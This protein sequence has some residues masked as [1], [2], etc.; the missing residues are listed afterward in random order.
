MALQQGYDRE[1]Q[2]SAHRTSAVNVGTLERINS[3]T[4]GTVPLLKGVKRHSWGEQPSQLLP[5][6]F[7]TGL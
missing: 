6:D 7:C 2:T 4:V 5:S 1:T 3:A